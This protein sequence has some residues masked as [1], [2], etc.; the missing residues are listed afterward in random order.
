MIQWDPIMKLKTTLSLALIATFLF[1]LMAISSQFSFLADDYIFL[2]RSFNLSFN[3]QDFGV[4]YARRPLTAFVNY[5]LL[6]LGLFD[7]L[8][9]LFCIFLFLHS[10]GLIQISNW[11]FSS[12]QQLNKTSSSQNTR[13]K[14]TFV[15]LLCLYPSLH[16]VML[17]PF[18][19]PYSLGTLFLAAMVL[20]SSIFMRVVW[21]LLAFCTLETYFVSALILP[22]LPELLSGATLFEPLKTNRFKIHSLTWMI[23]FLIYLGIRWRLSS[24]VSIASFDLDFSLS[25]LVSFAKMYG[26][27]LWTLHFYKTSWIFSLLEWI[28]ILVTI[29]SFSSSTREKARYAALLFLV[30]FLSMPQA[31][32]MTYYAPRAIHGA[33]V[34]K[35]ALFGNLLSLFSERSSSRLKGITLI[36]LMIAYLGET[37]IIFSQKTQNSLLLQRQEEIW[38]Q[39][40]RECQEPC[41]LSMGDL[42]HGLKRDWV[43]P[44]FAFEPFLRWIQHKNHIQKNISLTP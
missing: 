40:F 7:H 44:S 18:N 13:W 10:V 42:D 43:L 2:S 37:S 27:V 38:T 29:L 34:L 23:A 17:W 1:S 31:L 9:L 32:I 20:S 11:L 22:I 21:M 30:P 5:G 41:V 14:Y 3:L 24:H 15:I 35:L 25:H 26:S 28:A 6:K 8:K 12:V 36:L 39:K 33:V 19:L 4:I 16:E